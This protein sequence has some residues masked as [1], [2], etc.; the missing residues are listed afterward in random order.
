MTA[1]AEAAGMSRV[2]WHRLERGESS[3]AWGSMLA[4]VTV[5]GLDLRLTRNPDDGMA[6]EPSL[7]GFLPLRIRLADF[8]GLRRLAWQVGGGVE[9]PTPR[10]ALGLYARNACHL[11]T[12][13]LSTRERALLHALSEVFG[14][15]AADV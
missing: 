2:T 3:V 13:A 15:M 11:D 6:A 12:D 9:N 5:L 1:A 10:E 14:V 8:P 7:D 4:A